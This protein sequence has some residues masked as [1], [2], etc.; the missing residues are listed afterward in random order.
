MKSERL[1][2]DPE[3][4]QD[5]EIFSDLP[6]EQNDNSV[7]PFVAHL[8]YI[9]PWRKRPNPP[10]TEPCHR[11]TFASPSSST[12]A[13]GDSPIGFAFIGAGKAHD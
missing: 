11:K 13:P 8:W 10:M 6:F 4:R 5:I 3:Q 7:A 9:G 2:F 1:A 12:D